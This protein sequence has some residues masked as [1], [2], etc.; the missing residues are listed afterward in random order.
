MNLNGENK[1]EF[2]NLKK[3]S[4]FNA[5][6]NSKKIGLFVKGRGNSFPGTAY[7]RLLFSFDLIGSEDKYSPYIIDI[8]ELDNVKEDIAN[9]NFNL[10]VIIIQR[11]VLNLDLAK[12][13][14][15][16]CHELGIFIIY[17][18]DDDLMNI[19]S[20]HPEFDYYKTVKTTVEYIIKNSN[21]CT[22]STEKLKE[23]LHDLN[24][25]I[26][27]IPNRLIQQWDAPSNL[28]K[29]PNVI[30]IGYM[31]TTSHSNDLNLIKKAIINVKNHFKNKNINVVFEL[32]GGT[33]DKLD[34]ADKIEIPRGKT[35]YPLFV[36]WL[37]SIVN[38]DIAIAPLEDT[39]INKSKSELKYLEYSALNVPGIYSNIGPYKSKIIHEYNGLIVNNNTSDWEK[40][41]IKLIENKELQK[42]I[43]TN[44]KKDIQKNYLLKFSANQW[45]H[46]L[47]LSEFNLENIEKSSVNFNY[48]I[49]KDSYLFDE[50]YYINKYPDVNRSGMDPLLHYVK[51]GYKEGRDPCTE[52]SSNEYKKT[53]L[54]DDDSWNPLTHYILISKFRASRLIIP[55]ED[56]DMNIKIINDSHLFDESFYSDKYPDT[57][58]ADI[59]PLLHYVKFGFKEGRD[60]CAEFSTTNYKNNFLTDDRWNPLTHYILIGRYDKLE[61]KFNYNYNEK[62]ENALKKSMFNNDLT[63]IPNLLSNFNAKRILLTGFTNETIINKL[64][65]SCTKTHRQLY[66]IDDEQNIKDSIKENLLKN[67]N[68]TDIIKLLKDKTQNILQTMNNFDAIFIN[69]DPNWYTVFNELNLI[70]K[71]YLNFPLVFICH[72]KYPHKRRD[73]YINPDKIPNE[74]KHDCCRDLPVKYEENNKNKNAMIEDGFCHAIYKDTPKN[75]VLTA[76]EDFLNE[77][78]SLNL[79]ELN[80]LEGISLI[81]EDSFNTK[82]KI[83]KIFS[84]EKQFNYS[85][86]ELS[87]K[88]IENHLLLRKSELDISNYENEQNIKIIK[89]KDEEIEI[90]KKIESR[91]NQIN[92]PLKIEENRLNALKQEYSSQLAKIE[93]E[94]YDINYLK[95]EISNN[96]LEIIYLKKSTLT[97][98][99]LTPFAYIYLLFKS[100]PKEILINFKLY[101]TLKNNP[102]FDIGFYLNNDDDLMNSNWCRYF[103]PELHYV[104]KGFDENRLF[105]KKYFN[106]KSKKELLTYLLTCN[107]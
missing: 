66:I 92:T 27:V 90:Y 11:D 106:R 52:F 79:L 102:C 97:K 48:N 81:Y 77:N 95:E 50:N 31:G 57:I 1:M 56:Y 58:K 64:I 29:Q 22:V 49:I 10:D 80:F 8:D 105:N 83:Q 61:S 17:E 86:P 84:E 41:I 15:E 7:I 24:K 104:C 38:W 32:I 59:P 85:Y 94:K 26:Y 2:K 87:D 40:N 89:E 72:N 43:I 51:Q 33:E 78:L 36:E 74:Y 4:D 28:S 34:F 100:Q 21:V 6:E 30:K 42:N 70:K 54:M 63:I 16:K 75:G 13:I 5:N 18:I 71:N 88:A 62:N 35:R 46:I 44:S 60:P 98:K 107:K 65:T 76:I 3:Y 20:S 55:K 82:E 9:E 47:N 103:S 19:D 96:E 69:D 53:F 99:I 14:I 45:K 73:S 101:K 91:L 39:F 37:K 68:E 93:R 23:K 25:N 12:L 67:K